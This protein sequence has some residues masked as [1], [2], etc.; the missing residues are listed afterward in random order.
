MFIL[1]TIEDLIQIK[2]QDFH[3]PSAQAI[4]DAIHTKYSNK[5]IQNV[6]LGMTM[7]DLLEASEGLIG[8]GT[9]LVNVNVTFRLLTFRPFRSELLLGKIRRSTPEGITMNLDFTFDVYIPFEYLPPGTV[10]SAADSVFIWHTEDGQELFFD[11]G[12]PSL[13]RVVDEE[14]TDQKPGLVH[15]DDDG[16][17]VEAER[18][19]AWRVIG[20][21]A[22]AGLGPTLWWGGEVAEEDGEEYEGEEMEVDGEEMGGEEE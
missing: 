20:S 5:V 10:W 6:G 16:G 12:E 18:G 11:R 17:I 8:H 7:W 19:V 15:R 9:G 14:W 13:F 4:K 1:T 2:P 22:Q 3:V 21:M